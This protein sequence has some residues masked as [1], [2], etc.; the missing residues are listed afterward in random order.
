[1]EYRVDGGWGWSFGLLRLENGAPKPWNWSI[2]VM[3][4]HIIT[5]LK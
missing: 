5:L 3:E 1:V 2:R 4:P